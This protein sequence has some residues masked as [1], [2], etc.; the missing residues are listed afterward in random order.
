MKTKFRLYKT[1]NT[2]VYGMQAYGSGTWELSHSVSDITNGI[3]FWKKAKKGEAMKSKPTKVRT[4]Q[5][6]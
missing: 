2:Y 3:S 1:I 5:T 6:N 4:A